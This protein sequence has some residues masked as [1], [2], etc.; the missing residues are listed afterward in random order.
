MRVII[1]ALVLAA[2]SSLTGCYSIIGRVESGFGVELVK[3]SGK[4]PISYRGVYPGIQ[5]TT[6]IN[7]QTFTSEIPDKQVAMVGSTVVGGIDF[8]FSF[9][10]DTLLLPVDL[11][12]WAVTDKEADEAQAIGSAE[13]AKSEG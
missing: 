11:V 6:A 10:L 13:S 3:F 1:S 7:E 2:V 12:W 5:Y 9:A 4:Q 8:W